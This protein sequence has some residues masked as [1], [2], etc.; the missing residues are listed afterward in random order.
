M[1]NT[2]SSS[3]DGTTEGSRPDRTGRQ[4]IGKNSVDTSNYEAIERF[5]NDMGGVTRMSDWDYRWWYFKGQVRH[6]LGNHILVARE[7]W[8][9]GPEDSI[10][11]VQNGWVCW[12][13]DYAEGG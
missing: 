6:L 11:V 3:A 9:R 8:V 2:S 5:L 4:P 7:E 10:K 1:S 12:F 13:C